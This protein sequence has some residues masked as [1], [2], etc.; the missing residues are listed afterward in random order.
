MREHTSRNCDSA[1]EAVR[2]AHTHE[3]RWHASVAVLA[4]IALY[5]TLPNKI[6]FGPLWL[7]PLIIAILLVPLTV[8][9]P[10]RR[11]ETALQRWLSVMLISTLNAFNVATLVLLLIE[12]LSKHFHK[13]FHGQELLLAAVQIWVTNILVYGLWYWEIDG[14]GPN[15]RAHNAPGRFNR[16]ADFLFP[17]MTLTQE[18]QQKLNWQPKVFDYIFL[19]FTNASAFSPA[20]TF[21]L[22]RR[23]KV[24]MLAQSIVSL[25]TLAIIAS[26]AVGIL[27]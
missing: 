9:G 24:L 7:M 17:Q 4:G 8:I 2:P 27:A 25:T 12:I 10:V 20:D 21:P 22:S 11:E 5:V 15:A 26:R 13:D 6:T 3:P 19:A 14:G 18:Q 1:M 16:R 23:A